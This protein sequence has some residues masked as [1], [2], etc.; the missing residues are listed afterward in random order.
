MN[1]TQYSSVCDAPMHSLR[2]LLIYYSLPGLLFAIAA[3]GVVPCGGRKKSPRTLSIV[4]STFL[5]RS[6]EISKDNQEDSKHS[7]LETYF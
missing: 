7:H 6:F 1:L 4:Q 5:F 3:A 2:G